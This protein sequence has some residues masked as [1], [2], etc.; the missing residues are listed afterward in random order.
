MSSLPRTCPACRVRLDSRIMSQ[1]G[2]ACCPQCGTRLSGAVAD[3]A[4]LLLTGAD[5]T[6]AVAKVNRLP[7]AYPTRNEPTVAR[8]KQGSPLPILIALGVGLGLLGLF[9][10]GGSVSALVYFT[11]AREPSSTVQ[12]AAQEAS[13]PQ[14]VADMRPQFNPNPQP[15]V[16]PLEDSKPLGPPKEPI[17]PAQQQEA[18]RGALPLKELKAA[19]V[20]IKAETATMAAR[21]SGF[22]VRAQDDTAYVVTN[23]HVVTPPAD[24]PDSPLPPFVIRRPPG[25]G[26]HIPQMPIG[27]RM[28]PRPINPRIPR[29]GVSQLIPP[30]NQP[31]NQ[32][33]IQPA[34]PQAV[35]IVVVFY[36]GT[37][38]QQEL[39][40][41]LCADDAAADL[42]VLKVTGVRETPQPIDWKVD[43]ELMETMPSVAFGFPFGEKLDPNKQNPAVTVTKGAVSSLR[44][45]H[46]EL[47]EV[48]LDL[49]LNPGNSGGPV[50]DEKGT[51]IGVAV[52]KVTNSRIG[53]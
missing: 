5:R 30:A 2:A 7:S 23:H 9:I 44:R 6:P 40:A 29:R 31:G 3:D 25:I 19:T 42:A 45:S 10:I 35:R 48:Q 17:K 12:A 26:P 1:N 37:E 53:F 34:G 11:M 8:K 52:A 27:P 47:A 33:G 15:A 20:Y 50:V 14:P 51:L 49:D 32:P 38:K 4:T 39:P 28:P 21:G 46:G 13:A 18:G 24:E 43:P 22:V 41:I 16:P 36:S